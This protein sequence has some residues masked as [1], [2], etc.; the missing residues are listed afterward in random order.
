MADEI[1]FEDAFEAIILKDNFDS[2][3]FDVLEEVILSGIG[4]MTIGTTN[5][6][7]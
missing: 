4:F 1:I 7:G 2:I 3:I 6:V 5:I